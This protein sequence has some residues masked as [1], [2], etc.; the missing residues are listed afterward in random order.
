LRK[1]RSGRQRD[2]RAASRSFFMVSPRVLFEICSVSAQRESDSS[3][4]LRRRSQQEQ[5]TS[6]NT[7]ILLLTCPPTPTLGIA[8]CSR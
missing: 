5:P 8:T 6:N 2:E 1:N 3:Q 4:R 7:G